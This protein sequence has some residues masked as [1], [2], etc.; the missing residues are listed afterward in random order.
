VTKAEVLVLNLAAAAGID[1]ARERIVHSDGTPVALI[2]RFDRINGERIP[3]LSATSML[4]ASRRIIFNMLITNVDDHSNNHGFL[5][6]GHTF[7][8]QMRVP[9]AAYTP[10]HRLLRRLKKRS[11]SGMLVRNNI[12]LQSN[13]S[14][15]QNADRSI[16]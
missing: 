12:L 13:V 8:L 6:V 9:C 15:A 7:I 11:R 5:H 3:Y 16:P 10:F 2:R 14:R 1:A 4:Q